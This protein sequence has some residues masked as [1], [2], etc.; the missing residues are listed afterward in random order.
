MCGITGVYFFKDNKNVNL[1][2]IKEMTTN[3]SHR[4]PDSFGYWS[5]EV[6]NVYFGHRRLS[7]LD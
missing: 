6:N 3:L 5:S 7:I 1:S 4:G 2:S